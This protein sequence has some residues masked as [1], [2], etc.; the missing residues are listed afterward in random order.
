ME[1]AQEDLDA[2]RRVATRLKTLSRRSRLAVAQLEAELKQLKESYAEERV[3]D[4]FSASYSY[5]SD[6]SEYDDYESYDDKEESAAKGEERETKEELAAKSEELKEL[7]QADPATKP[8]NEELETE[9]KCDDDYGAG[10]KT[11]DES[12]EA[13]CDDNYGAKTGAKTEESVDFGSAS[14][15]GQQATDPEA[16]DA[17]PEPQE[18]S[19]AEPPRQPGR[20]ELSSKYRC[21]FRVARLGR[22]RV[23]VADRVV[24]GAFPARV[25]FCCSG[26]RRPPSVAGFRISGICPARSAYRQVRIEPRIN[27]LRFAFRVSDT[28]QA[29]RRRLSAGARQRSRSAAAVVARLRARM[30]TDNPQAPGG[31]TPGGSP[32]Y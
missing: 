1:T 2:A 22:R 9:A 4:V 17:R 13:K 28:T 19:S 18:L 14:D 26:P 21:V 29:R 7:E 25:F 32:G 5:A 30:S 16:N 8:N 27:K 12:E 20:Q 3:E 10:A 11:E 31:P 23:L 6:E 15:S 24:I